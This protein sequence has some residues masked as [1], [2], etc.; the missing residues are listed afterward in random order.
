MSIQFKYLFLYAIDRFGMH[1][2]N[3][4]IISLRFKI[5]ANDGTDY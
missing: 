4:I 3:K 5:W 2:Q 1:L